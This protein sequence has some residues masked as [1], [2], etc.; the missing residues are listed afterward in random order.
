[1]GIFFGQGPRQLDPAGAVS[2]IRLVLPLDHLEMADEIVLHGD[3]EHTDAVPVALSGSHD[4]LVGSEVHIL[5]AKAGALKEAEPRAIEQDG[6]QSGRPL[7]LT[8]HGA[9]LVPG[10]DNGESFASF[11]ADHVVEPWKVD[12]EDGAQ[13]LVLGRRCDVATDSQRAQELSNFGSAHLGGV[14]LAVKQDVAANPGD[15]RLFGS[16]AAVSS[17]QRLADPV[18]KPGLARPKVGRARAP[19]G[20]VWALDESLAPED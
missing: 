4:D 2:E 3:R 15:V 11:G 13:R 8:D 1:V 10:E 20:F 6:H 5:D 19:P 18:E 16:A 12:L 7:E 17:A 9:H 14:A